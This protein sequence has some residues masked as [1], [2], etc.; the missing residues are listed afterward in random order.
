M[1]SVPNSRLAVF[2]PLVLLVLV[3]VPAS[4]DKDPPPQ[5]VVTSVTSTPDGPPCLLTLKGRNF[6][7]GPLEIVLGEAPMRLI[8]RS[9]TWAIAELDCSTEAGD[10]LLAVAR[11]PSNTD[12]D[13]LSLTIGAVGPQGPEGPMGPVGPLGP[14][15]PT[16]PPGPA[17]AGA[18]VFAEATRSFYVTEADPLGVVP[19]LDITIE[20]EPGSRLLVLLD[21]PIYDGCHT[22]D[23]NPLLVRLLVDGTVVAERSPATTWTLNPDRPSSEH[24][25]YLTSALSAGP[26]RVHVELEYDGTMED[27]PRNRTYCVG[28]P[29]DPLKQSHLSVVELRQ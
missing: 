1:P 5:L 11:G 22:F 6:G 26:H 12:R 4:A 29:G 21:A 13:V 19:G 14:A 27:D 24:V 15:G 17:L 20:V 18:S 9:G 2:L 23:D 10:H 3:A 28:A 7:D 25:T 8:D 16:G